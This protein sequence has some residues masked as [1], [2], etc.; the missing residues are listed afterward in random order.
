MYARCCVIRRN[1]KCQHWTPDFIDDTCYFWQSREV[2]YSV[3]IS[4]LFTTYTDTRRHVPSHQCE[5]HVFGW[6]VSFGVCSLEPWGF[7]Y[8][9]CWTSLL[10]LGFRGEHLQKQSL[11]CHNVNKHILYSIESILWHISE[12]TLVI[13]F[14][15][16]WK[17]N[18]L[19]HGWLGI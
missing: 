10:L 3:R 2:V 7:Y 16:K 8:T 6:Y 13:P 1:Y 9:P 5:C 11:F 15:L 18:F 12:R 14:L 19:S 4:W 17:V